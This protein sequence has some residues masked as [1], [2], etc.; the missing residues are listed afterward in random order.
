[1]LEGIKKNHYYCDDNVIMGSKLVKVGNAPK[2]AITYFGD[3]N[4]F[5]SNF[6]PC[7]V[8]YGGIIYPT[9]E[10]AFQ[11]AKTLDKDLRMQ[12]SHMKSP[13]E[14]KAAGRSLKLRP[15]WEKI[16]ND[17]MYKLLRL[18]F[19]QPYFRRRLLGTGSVLLIEGNW[20]HDTYWG[21]YEGRGQN[22]LGRMLMRIRQELKEEQKK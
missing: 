18:K 22:M 6:F 15:D 21:V 17:V 14:A 5:L 1:M 19:E 12:I 16:K 13:N 7:K 4:W 20:W 10:H 11:A 8:E 9:I 3:G 2:S